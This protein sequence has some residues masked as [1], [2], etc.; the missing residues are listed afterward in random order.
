MLSYTLTAI[1]VFFL[2]ANLRL[3]RAVWAARR[4]RPTALLAWPVPRPRYYLL[5][6][7]MALVLGV[8]VLVKLGVARRPPQDVFG[9]V[10]MLVYFGYLV[11]FSLRIERGFY[12]RGLWLD[13]DGFLAYEH[14]GGLSWR[15]V[16][17]IALLA[18]PRRR[19]VARRLVVPREHYAEARRLL[20]D[21]MAT[22]QI[23]VREVLDLGVHDARDDV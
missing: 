19:Q 14:I 22:H 5:Y 23:E 10:M 17:E 15:E 8:L 18:V 3:A 11:P 4:L 20:R 21:R 12:E 2:F 1:G 16:P 13:D 9:E 7:V 6:L